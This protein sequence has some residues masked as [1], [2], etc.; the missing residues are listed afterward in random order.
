MSWGEKGQGAEK[1]REAVAHKNS[2]PPQ[3][4]RPP[5]LLEGDKRS[6]GNLKGKG[7]NRKRPKRWKNCTPLFLLLKMSEAMR[8]PERDLHED[9]DM[10]GRDQREGIH[11]GPATPVASDRRLEVTIGPPI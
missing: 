11:R 7:N 1:K 3:L 8:K 9:G 4:Q 6:L 10:A 5:T 2:Q